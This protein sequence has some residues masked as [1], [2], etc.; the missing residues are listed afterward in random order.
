[1]IVKVAGGLHQAG[2]GKNLGFTFR[3]FSR[4]LSVSLVSEDRPILGTQCLTAPD[5]CL[6]PEPSPNLIPLAQSKVRQP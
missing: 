1:M 4:Q 2:R 5:L 3:P 6:Q